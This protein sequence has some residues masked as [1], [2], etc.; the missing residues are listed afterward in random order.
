MN[1]VTLVLR[2]QVS[3]STVN[4]A[5]SQKQTIFDGNGD[6]AVSVSIW[7]NHIAFGSEAIYLGN[8]DS[9]GVKILGSVGVNE[10][11]QLHVH[12]CVHFIY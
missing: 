8:I 1:V 4:T 9:T 5:G 12:V 7:R 6:I 10:V 3:T 11:L 2:L